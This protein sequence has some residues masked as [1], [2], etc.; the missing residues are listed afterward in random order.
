MS[1]IPRGQTHY[2]HPPPIP[3][4]PSRCST[5]FDCDQEPVWCRGITW[6]SG[7]RE[8]FRLDV[9]AAAAEIQ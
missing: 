2:H 8:D 7:L 6:F 5:Q 9:V 3:R 4:V 1:L